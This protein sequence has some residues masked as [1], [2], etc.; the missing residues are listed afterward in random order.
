MQEPI[1]LKGKL[2][3]I[4]FNMRCIEIRQVGG[5]INMSMEINFNMRCIEMEILSD[6]KTL[7][8]DKLQH[9]MY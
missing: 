5:A 8:A 6:A 2:Y 7:E 3:S 9:E 1:D 4:N